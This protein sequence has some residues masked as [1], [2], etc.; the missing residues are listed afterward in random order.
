LRSSDYNAA[1]VGDPFQDFEV[2]SRFGSFG[3]V[4]G[5][6]KSSR[7]SPLSSKRIER[8]PRQAGRA[9]GAQ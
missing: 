7:H 4:S 6:P 8:S 5:D 2:R 3:D 9:P 1:F